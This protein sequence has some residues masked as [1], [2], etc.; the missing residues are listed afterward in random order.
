MI[1]PGWVLSLWDN[2]ALIAGC[3][4]VWKSELLKKTSCKRQTGRPFGSYTMVELRARCLRARRLIKWLLPALL[5]W[6][7]VTQLLTQEG[8]VFPTLAF[9]PGAAAQ[10]LARKAGS[11]LVKSMSPASLL[12]HRQEMQNNHRNPKRASTLS[13]PGVLCPRPSR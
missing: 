7:K 10:C 6:Q 8:W 2:V 11:I 13:I 4:G 3:G 12:G 9:K 5:W 1:W